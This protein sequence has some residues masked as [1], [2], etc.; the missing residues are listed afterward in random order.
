MRNQLSFVFD[1]PIVINNYLSA[2]Y[3]RIRYDTQ[4]L[5]IILDRVFKQYKA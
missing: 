4:V 3:L 2:E 1:H 5:D